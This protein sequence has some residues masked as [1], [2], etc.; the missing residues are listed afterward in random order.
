MP[1]ALRT[2]LFNHDVAN[3][4]TSA[5]NIRKNKDFETARP[6]Y[7]SGIARAPADQC[8]AYA[9]ATTRNR[10]VKVRCTFELKGGS[11][12]SFEVK[13]TGGGVLGNL[14]PRVV[15]FA[16]G[17]TATVDFP[18]DHRSF[19]AIGRHDVTWQWS[20][21]VGGGPFWQPLVTTSHRIYLLLDVP[22]PPW[23]QTFADKHNPWTDLLDHTCAIASNRRK[24]LDAAIDLVKAIYGDY[25][26]RYDIVSGAPRYGFGGTSGS[27]RMTSWIAWVLLGNP[28]SSPTFCQGSGESYNDNWIVNCYDAAASLGLMGRCM[29]VDLQYHFHQPFGFLRYVQPIG[30]GRCNN[31]F[32]GCWSNLP[33]VGPDDQRSAF[34][35]HA[36][37]KL[38]GQNDF[39]A[40]MK[41]WLSW[42]EQLILTIIYYILWLLIL[43]LTLGLV[44]AHYL[45]DRAQGWL[46]N[47]AQADYDAT[48]IDTSTPGE[49]AFAGGVPVFCALDFSVL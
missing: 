42:I 3:P 8:A 7:D 4:A 31:P 5:L 48:V 41:Q 33:A 15:S 13:A 43:I 24:D 49:A 14:D 30:R 22:C 10:A 39:D 28:P 32:Y 12:T 11:K 16:G 37:T 21:R 44:D 34:G 25:S 9:I 35:N 1:I 6:E 47:M 17:S 36:Y 27:F 19:A 18:L 2:I 20:V 26:L 29:G 40:C 46:V 38:R 23:S 45:L